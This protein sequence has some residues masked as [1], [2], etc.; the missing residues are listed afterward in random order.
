LEDTGDSIPYAGNT[1]AMT[2]APLVLISR[3]TNV[4]ATD[5]SYRRTRQFLNAML[6]RYGVEVSTAPAGDYDALVDAIKPTTRVLGSESP[7]NPYNRIIDLERFAAIGRKHRV[8]T[9]IDATFATPY[10]AR[11]L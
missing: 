6:P 10:N 2:T 5:D 11:P 9:V 8:K 3:G 7:T 1:D 4:V